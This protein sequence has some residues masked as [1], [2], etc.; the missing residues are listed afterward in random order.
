MEKL[1]APDLKALLS[2][3]VIKP[4][5]IPQLKFEYKKS[6]IKASTSIPPNSFFMAHKKFEHLFLM[7]ASG[8]EMDRKMYIIGPGVTLPAHL[9][10]SIIPVLCYLIAFPDRELRILE[11]KTAQPGEPPNL[12]EQS[13]LNVINAAKL[14]WVMRKYNFKS[15]VYEYVEAD[16]D[17]APVPTWPDIDDFMDLLGKAYEGRVIDSNQHPVY[18]ELGGI[19]ATDND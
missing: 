6:V 2:Q 11:I 16:P 5:D 15:S 4:G 12:R 1:K 13:N 7:I 3:V 10:D 14:K 9:S 8:K 19:K 18:L 17:Y